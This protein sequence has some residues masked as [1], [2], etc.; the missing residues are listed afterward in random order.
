MDAVAALAMTVNAREALAAAI[1]RNLV[2]E[3]TLEQTSRAVE[4]AR[5][6]V[7][8]MNSHLAQFDDLDDRIA[9]ARAE[10]VTRGDSGKL[11]GILISD[12]EARRA[13]LERQDECDRALALIQ[14]QHA[15][16]ENARRDAADAVA[17]AAINVALDEAT[18]LSGSLRAAQERVRHLS[19]RLYALDVVVGGL[20]ATLPPARAGA[21]RRRLWELL[22]PL[23]VQRQ[24]LPPG[25]LN[26]PCRLHAE[27]WRAFL[28]DLRR[29]PNARLSADWEEQ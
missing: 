9:A 28:G 25:A 5:A 15:A 8:A 19:S 6:A 7:K 29:D 11:P 21:P 27:R 23:T 3:A 22:K 17:D 2:A 18:A 12:R 10:M 14:A 24:E 20:T 16:A 4:Q 1:D 26:S 13:A